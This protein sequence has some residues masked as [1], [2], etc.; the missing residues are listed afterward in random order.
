[1]EFEYIH[2]PAHHYDTV[3]INGEPLLHV[4]NLAYT[5]FDEPLFSRVL[6][7]DDH[8]DALAFVAFGLPAFAAML[9]GIRWYAGYALDY[10]GMEIVKEDPRRRPYKR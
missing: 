5:D 4:Y 10:P 6:Y 8:G 1:M 3:L 2:A 7:D 9:N